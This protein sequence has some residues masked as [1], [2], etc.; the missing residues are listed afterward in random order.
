MARRPQTLIRDMNRVKEKLAQLR[1]QLR[2]IQDE[3]SELADL[4]ADAVE[5]LDYVVDRLSEQV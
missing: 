4:S 1:D 2:E 3:A 5:S